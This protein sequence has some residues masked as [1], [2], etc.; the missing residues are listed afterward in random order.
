MN[1]ICTQCKSNFR[2]PGSGPEDETLLCPVC[3]ARL[4]MPDK[5][6]RSASA[7]IAALGV[8]EDA[9]TVPGSTS[10]SSTGHTSIAG[11]RYL[12][13]KSGD[14]I[15]G[16]RLE[17]IL[18][19]GAMAVV[20]KATQLS[21]NRLV[22]LKILPEKFA[23]NKTFVSR[24]DKE[25]S[26]LASL[27]HPNIVTIIDRGRE[28][29]TY[30]FAM[31][32]IDGHSLRQL[33][34][35]DL[36]LQKFLK[37]MEQICGAMHYAHSRGVVH[38]DIKPSNIMLNS[39]GEVKIADFGLAG[40][41]NEGR[42][43]AASASTPSRMGTRGYM[44]PEQIADPLD[45]DGRAD[46][47]SLGV[48][49]Y[50]I[51]TRELPGPPPVIPPSALNDEADPRLDATVEKCLEFNRE[52]RYARATE[53]LEG[54]QK[55]QTE[56]SSAP[57]CPKCGNYSPV[58]FRTCKY[59]NNSLAEFF[60]VCPSCGA[61]N[62]CDVSVCFECGADLAQKRVAVSARMKTLIEKATENTEN[63][64]F[65]Q[66]LGLL[67][68]V[69]S[70]PGKTFSDLRAGA[71]SQRERIGR[72][73]KAAAIED[74]Q[75][76][77][78]LFEQNRAKEAIEIWQRIPS[79]IIDVSETIQ[80]AKQWQK[81]L[82]AVDG[83][84]GSRLLVKPKVQPPPL[85]LN[86]EVKAGSERQKPS[87]RRTGLYVGLGISAALIVIVAGIVAFM[88]G[89]NG[90]IG[91][92]NPNRSAREMAFNL[93]KAGPPMPIFHTH[94][95]VFNHELWQPEGKW[96]RYAREWLAN[97][98]P[99]KRS[100]ILFDI[101]KVQ[102]AKAGVK[103]QLPRFDSLK[104]VRIALLARRN[105]DDSYIA[106]QAVGK[107]RGKS[108]GLEFRLITK[109]GGRTATGESIETLEQIN[110]GEEHS[111]GVLIS[112]P[113]IVGLF[114]GR[115]VA[116]I[117]N[118]TGVIPETGGIGISVENAV[119]AWK[120]LSYSVALGDE[121]KSE[122]N[123]LRSVNTKKRVVELKNCGEF[124]LTALSDYGFDLN[125]RIITAPETQTERPNW[126]ITLGKTNESGTKVELIIKPAGKD[127][128]EAYWLFERPGV[129]NEMVRK[130]LPR[131]QRPSFE[132]LPG[133]H[134][135]IAVTCSPTR[136]ALTLD[137][138]EL[139]SEVPPEGFV[140][141]R[142][143][144]FLTSNSIRSRWERLEVQEL[145]EYD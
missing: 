81:E 33:M 6:N 101:E 12:K 22:A 74:Y 23:E 8:S 53:L 30:F 138:K 5:E 87:R 39:Q 111:L 43:K 140:F 2:L 40:L 77:Q 46:I 88:N 125:G 114:D 69:V 7:D 31:E 92:V 51:L 11:T 94:C 50:Q 49:M 131:G 42:E 104:G 25:S 89:G 32:Y 10:A 55:L 67:D 118:A 91:P 113:S 79:D 108:N 63:K 1:F 82:E 97:A 132:F 107:S 96:G 70:I 21:L 93:V 19:A 110:E 142:G 86:G 72:Q 105:S 35:R 71:E 123:V 98:A 3:G 122:G 13:V 54:L 102:M 109:H 119:S 34:K 130:E 80:Q 17:H 115:P 99:D 36:P 68:E 37:I 95:Y 143:K 26:A 141:F 66:A 29:K 61:E 90:N 59:C 52:K 106:M 100:F 116:I 65:D 4:K 28:K 64:L 41:M 78:R 124:F 139:L 127:R 128:A 9:P 27:N 134:Y 76:G 48:L 144:A 18:G 85:P 112:E 56:I 84:R 44:A 58:R 145:L 121:H 133:R 75:A 117:E 136:C 103:F 57:K 47:Y 38:R 126:T 73:R 83:D 62:R 120:D 14:I 60:D 20:Y 135:T 15:S 24:F 129:G 45:V 137:A 16:F